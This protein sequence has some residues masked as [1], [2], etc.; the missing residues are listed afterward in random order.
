M[1]KVIPFRVTASQHLMIVKEAIEHKLSV[2]DLII[3][4]LFGDGKIADIGPKQTKTLVKSYA[5]LPD[6]IDE[7]NKYGF[8]YTELAKL[9]VGNKLQSV[10]GFEAHFA[11][12]GKLR[13]SKLS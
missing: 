11:K 9:R 10:E 3:Y 6:L 13:V 7:R 12:R 2:S 1:S 4:K 8:G 5:K